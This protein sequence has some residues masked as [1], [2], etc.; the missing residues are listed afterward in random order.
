VGFANRKPRAVMYT[1]TCRRRSM[2]QAPKQVTPFSNT[3]GIPVATASQRSAATTAATRSATEPWYDR[4]QYRG[5]GLSL[6]NSN[7]RRGMYPERQVKREPTAKFDKRVAPSPH[8]L[9]AAAAV[10]TAAE[11]RSYFWVLIPR[12][13]DSH[14]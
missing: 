7:K 14:N 6:S 8:L 4:S 1:R 5:D 13:Q 11:I 10:A 12:E 9:G 2:N 3:V